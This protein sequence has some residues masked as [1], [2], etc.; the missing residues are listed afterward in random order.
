VANAISPSQTTLDDALRAELDA[1]RSRD[2]G[3]TLRVVARRRGAVVDTEHGPA[4]DFAS[5]DYLGLASD[6]RVADAAVRVLREQGVG[7]GAARLITGNTPEHEGLEGALAEFFD[8][9]R[10]LSFSSG[11]SANVGVIPALVGRGDAIFADAL[12]HASL[13]DGCRLSRA[14][15]HVYPHADA[16]ALAALLDAHRGA[17]RRALIVTDGLFS[18]DGDRAPLGEIVD[19]ARRFDA[20]TYLDDAHAA[21]VCGATGQGSASD[22]GRHGAIDVTV[23]T[24]GKAFGTAGAFVYGS[25]TLIEY[26]LNRARSFVFSTA[27]MPAQAAAAREAIR[28][29]RAEPK[30]RARVAANARLMRDAL[31]NARIHPSGD[32]SAHIVP[33]AIGDAAA[34]MHAGAALASRGFLVG[35]VRPPTV[36]QGTS[37]LRIT[38]SAAQTA[39][40]IARF[41][42]A[43]SIVL[44]R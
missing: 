10:A 11:Y 35:A 32:E 15:V 38:M 16:G 30:R 21:G 25:S 37:R 9:E 1:L 22:A 42:D 14:D 34:T 31:R 26:V 17:A 4:I 40:H 2:L 12:N 41:A 44:R 6:S 39:E 8:A 19:L 33:V 5:N 13:I 28:I 3:R 18:M 29:V 43:L 27:M 20:W 36:P 23:A 7:A 24:L